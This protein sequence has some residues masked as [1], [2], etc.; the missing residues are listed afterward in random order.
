MTADRT[1]HVRGVGR[2][3]VYR[4]RCVW[5]AHIYDADGVL[6]HLAK[7]LAADVAQTLGAREA[8]GLIE[9]AREVRA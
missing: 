8:R 7:P 4:N 5:W 6:L 2:V 9:R 1:I 3:R